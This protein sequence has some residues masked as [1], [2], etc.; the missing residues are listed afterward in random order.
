[1][2]FFQKSLATITIKTFS[3]SMLFYGRISFFFLYGPP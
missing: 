3:L 1:M 2:K